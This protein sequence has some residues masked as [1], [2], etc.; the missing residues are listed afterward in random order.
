MK[1]IRV[2]RGG[3]GLR[4]RIE[5]RGNHALKIK[6]VFV[7]SN[8]LIIWIGPMGFSRTKKVNRFQQTSFPLCISTDNQIT[9]IWK[10]NLAIYIITEV[11]QHKVI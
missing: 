2:R 4:S 5:V 9:P 11:T 3:L 1:K 7:M 8:K 6:P 10:I